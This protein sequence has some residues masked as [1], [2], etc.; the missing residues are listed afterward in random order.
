MSE[1]KAEVPL[2]ETYVVRKYIEAD[3]EAGEAP[4]EEITITYENGV[5]VRQDVVRKEDDDATN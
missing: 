2:T 4:Y 3:Y 5:L 1:D